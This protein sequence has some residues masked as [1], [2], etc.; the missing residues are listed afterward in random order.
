MRPGKCGRI[1]GAIRLSDIRH[2]IHDSPY[3]RQTDPTVHGRLYT[4]ISKYTSLH[5]CTIAL[6]VLVEQATVCR[7]HLDTRESVT[8]LFASRL[9]PTRIRHPRPTSAPA[10]ADT[11]PNLNFNLKSP[12]PLTSRDT[13]APKPCRLPTRALCALS[14]ERGP[15]QPPRAAADPGAKQLPKPHFP[16]AASPRGSSAAAHPTA[17]SSAAKTCP[18]RTSGLP[19]SPP[20]WDPPTPPLA[21]S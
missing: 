15:R 7:R 13:R 6:I 18:R 4:S 16:T 12:A 8:R 10:T 5:H 17:S 3:S 14:V 20:P 2:A 11:R 21:G 19:S 9:T 1:R